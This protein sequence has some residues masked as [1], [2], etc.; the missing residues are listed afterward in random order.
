MTHQSVLTLVEK[1]GEGH[2]AAV[3]K[4]R[5]QLM[6]Q[7]QIPESEQVHKTNLQSYSKFCNPPGCPITV[8]K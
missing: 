7:L 3:K 1:L 8:V 4:W 2:N 5:D 6:S